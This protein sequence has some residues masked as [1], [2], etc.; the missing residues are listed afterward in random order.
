MASDLAKLDRRGF[1]G[2][3]VGLAAALAAPTATRAEAPATS[4]AVDA[5]VE[6]RV[7]LARAR[8]PISKRR[9]PLL[10]QDYVAFRALAA[11][12]H[13]SLPPS[14]PPASVYRVPEAR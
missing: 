12:L 10:L 5:A 8:L 2:A 11:S 13:A 6:L 14:L 7:L 1:H 4:D 9:W 3:C